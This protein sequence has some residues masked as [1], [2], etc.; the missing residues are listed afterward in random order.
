MHTR[1]LGDLSLVIYLCPR[2]EGAGNGGNYERNKRSG[3][4]NNSS[5]VT[6]AKQTFSPIAYSRLNSVIN[7]YGKTWAA[8]DNCTHFATKHGT[9]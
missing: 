1:V 5:Q 6:Y 9:L 3:Y 4:A 8:A 2:N 7:S